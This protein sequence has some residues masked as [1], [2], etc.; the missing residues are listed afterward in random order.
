M[1]SLGQFQLSLLKTK[2]KEK[3]THASVFSKSS[4]KHRRLELAACGP[5]NA[6]TSFQTIDTADSPREASK[7]AQFQIKFKL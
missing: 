5:R 1:S 2:K 6:H 7:S 3:E 4:N